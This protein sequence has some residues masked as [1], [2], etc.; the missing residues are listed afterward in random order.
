MC[1][2]FLHIYI[3]FF[4]F[5][6]VILNYYGFLR[7]PFGP[8]WQPIDD[9][10]TVIRWRKWMRWSRFARGSSRYLGRIDRSLSL[11]FFSFSFCSAT[12][13]DVVYCSHFCPFFF[14]YLSFFTPHLIVCPM[15]FVIWF[16]LIWPAIKKEYC[17]D[18]EIRIK[19]FCTYIQFVYKYNSFFQL[20]K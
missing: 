16:D 10:G 19:L 8:I 15:I 2:T 6:M 11:S 9:L 12:D 3:Y 1:N 4:I 14:F 17:I 18:T 20:F 7:D 13:S 5:L